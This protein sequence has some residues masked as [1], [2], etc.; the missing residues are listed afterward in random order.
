MLI[1]NYL[2]PSCFALIALFSIQFSFGQGQLQN[3]YFGQYGALSFDCDVNATNVGNNP[4][5]SLEGS[6]TASDK[7]G[8]LL[9]FVNP[10]SFN[11]TNVN[12]G[13][14]D[15]SMQ[16][17]PGGAI[18]AS[19]GSPYQGAIYVPIGND[20]YYVFVVHDISTQN[21]ETYYSLVDMSL[22][23]NGT[24]ANP[25]GDVVAGQHMI[26]LETGSK[27]SVTAVRHANGTDYW[28]I[29]PNTNWFR[30]YQ[31]SSTGISAPVQS[32]MTTVPGG[33]NAAK[34]ANMVFTPDGSKMGYAF[35]IVDFN[36]A[37]GQFSNLTSILGQSL[38]TGMSPNCRHFFRI[39]VYNG[40]LEMYDLANP[41]AAPQVLATGFTSSSSN[42]KMVT[43]IDGNIYVKDGPSSIGRIEN[44]D[45]PT[46]TFVPNVIT[47][48][49]AFNSK[50]LPNFV[51]SWAV[52]VRADAVLETNTFTDCDS[53]VYTFTPEHC[54][55]VTSFEWDFGDGTTSTDEFPTHAY[56][57]P[58]SYTV[59]LVVR[60]DSTCSV[61]NT[62]TLLT[63]LNVLLTGPGPI[64]IA[65]AGPFCSTDAS[66][67]LNGGIAGGTWSGT[68][69]TD[70]LN[71][72]FDPSTAGSGTH[73]I[74]YATTGICPQSETVDISV[75][76]CTLPVE[77][78]NFNATAS[79]PDQVRLTWTTVTEIDNDYFEVERSP[80]AVNFSPI[81]ITVQGAGNTT[82]IQN[83]IEFDDD[84]Y[85]GINYYR[86][87]Q[88]DFDGTVNY[89][90]IRSVVFDDLTFV[91][92]FPNPANDEIQMTVMV[93]KDDDLYVE[94][95]DATGRAVI[96]S[97]YFIFEGVS[98]VKVDISSLATGMYTFRINTTD[99][100]HLSK[101]F[102]RN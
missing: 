59:E 6:T 26:L 42:S 13:I 76:D 44:P 92:L 79:G 91:N 72:T 66:S 8:N 38:M 100:N 34:V 37:T 68:G 95:L 18:T 3:W 86:L 23:G 11:L 84:P 82:Q 89:S 78:V 31:V 16:I 69:I 4:N 48:T 94:I 83:Y 62:D 28:V 5:Y 57:A 90:D 93:D 56:Q 96:Q 64:Q 99:E 39:P 77:L 15:A 97:E 54:G 29:C 27:Q 102:I 10:M 51:T 98:T 21:S 75:I 87:K 73:T 52:E 49:G 35:G 20:Q 70:P 74:T 1:N 61:W 55:Y 80:N 88:V 2:K 43:H 40:S 46:P 85:R 12:G 47:T 58:G 63:T 32:N 41:T 22:P 7:Q 14:Y 19:G 45:S 65:P 101:E 9:F 53:A 33:N 81:G 67:G 60:N 24:L 50:M 17:M 30:A 25:L 71:G 36:N